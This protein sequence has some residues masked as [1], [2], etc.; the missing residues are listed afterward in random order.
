MNDDIGAA[1]TTIDFAATCAC[2]N[3][4]KGARALT[5]FYDAV[6]RPTGLRSTQATLLMAIA[7]A[8][9]PTI[10]LLA[11]ALV[12]DRT[13]LGRDLK[14]L[15]AQGLVRIT[16]GDDRRMRQVELTDAGRAKRREIIPLWEQAQAKIIGA[17][18]GPERWGQLYKDL[19]E[20]VRL[21]QA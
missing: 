10:S 14:P 18:L 16:P 3:V 6:L 15:V 12:M 1:D 19:Q 4:R 11:E 7:A 9:R 8:G 2:F 21:A 20:V 17:G 5:G 13:T